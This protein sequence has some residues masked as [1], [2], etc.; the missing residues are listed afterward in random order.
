MLLALAKAVANATA[1][2]V[3]KAKGVA[4]KCDEQEDQNRVIGSAT[5]CALS[6]SQLVACTKVVAPTVHNPACQEQLV[7]AAKYV[8]KSVDGVVGTAQSACKDDASLQDLGSAATAVTKALDDLLQ[9]IRRGGPGGREVQEV[10]TILTATDRLF[11]SMDDTG[12]MVRQARVLAQA[13]S[14]LVNALKGEAESH[15]DSDMQKRLL[16]AA[17]QVRGEV[18]IGR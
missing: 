13:T 9:H 18:K 14:M 16:A 2:L 1:A 8:A 15:T 7:E 5:Q 17:K 10:D 12:E 3:L 6:T 11:S 4:G